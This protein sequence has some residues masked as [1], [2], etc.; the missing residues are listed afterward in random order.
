MFEI[1]IAAS[2][3]LAGA[4]ASVAGFGIGSILTPLPSLHAGTRLAVAAISIPRMRFGPRTA[5]I[6]G[7]LSAS[8]G[9][10]LGTLSGTR[11]LRRI[12]QPVFERVVATIVLALGLFMLWRAFR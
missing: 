4:I 6:A 10:L 5:W 1:A 8:A 11:L 9:V 7:G 3:F 2:S 12:P